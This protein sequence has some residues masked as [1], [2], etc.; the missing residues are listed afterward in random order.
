MRDEAFDLFQDGP[1]CPHEMSTKEVVACSERSNIKKI[2]MND[3]SVFYWHHDIS[4][5]LHNDYKSYKIVFL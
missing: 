2:E 5:L 4:Y 3:G 1:F